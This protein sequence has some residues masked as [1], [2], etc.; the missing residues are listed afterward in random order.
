[1]KMSWQEVRDVWTETLDTP[2]ESNDSNDS[3]AAFLQE[4]RTAESQEALFKAVEK[5]ILRTPIE[6]RMSWYEMALSMITHMRAWAWLDGIFSD[7][8][9]NLEAGRLHDDETRL[10]R[11]L[12]FATALRDEEQGQ[13]T[14]AERG[15]QALAEEDHGFMSHVSYVMLGMM[16]HAQNRTERA[17]SCLEAS[18]SVTEDL[19]L[20]AV[21]Y[22]RSLLEVL[23][24]TSGEDARVIAYQEAVRA[25]G[26]AWDMW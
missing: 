11:G 14:D 16:A 19:N 13:T 24:P 23:T 6:Q 8:R 20:R 18:R 15:F 1:M 5:V 3:N 10:A 21:G 2:E 25:K 17:L 9:M 12:V 4:M 26:R 22:C 7:V